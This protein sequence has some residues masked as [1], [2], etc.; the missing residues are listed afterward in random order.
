[1]LFNSYVFIFA[2]LPVTLLGYYL[3]PQRRLQLFFLLLCSLA[4]YAYWS[5]KLVL[6]LLFTV[7][8][9]FYVARAIFYAK[10]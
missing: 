9:D 6:L 8:L 1:M 3:I 2:F 7:V 5:S 4:F 10:L